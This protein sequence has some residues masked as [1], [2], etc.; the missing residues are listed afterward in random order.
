MTR[1]M[2]LVFTA[3]ILTVAAAVATSAENWPQ[4]RG[5]GGLGISKEQRLPTEWAPDKNMLW[6]TELP[7][8]GHSSPVVWGDRIFLTSVIEGEKLPGVKPP[9]HTLGGQ[10]F[11][12]PES[13]A[14]DLKHTFNVFAVDAK[15]GKIV[16]QHTP[17]QG[18]VYDARHRRSSFAA[19]TAATD[20]KMGRGQRRALCDHRVRQDDGQGSLASEESRHV[21]LGHPRHRECWRPR[22]VDYERI[23]I[24]HRL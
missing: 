19:P 21:E 15:T 17:Y 8:T 18:P 14:S 4:W 13:V 1:P 16:W 3:S 7:G 22:R 2:R 24:H 9:P 11:V 20:G 6:K 12:H 5:P 10:P 23:G